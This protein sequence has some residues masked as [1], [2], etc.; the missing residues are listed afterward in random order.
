MKSPHIIEIDN[1]RRILQPIQDLSAA[2]DIPLL[3]CLNNYLSHLSEDRVAPGAL[4][5]VKAGLFVRSSTAVLCVRS[6]T[7][8]DSRTG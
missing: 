3:D 1:L 2:W 4:N 5:F 7:S 6:N 8:T